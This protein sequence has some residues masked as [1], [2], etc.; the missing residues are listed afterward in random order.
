MH[1]AAVYSLTTPE[2]Q[3]GTAGAPLAAERLWK[4]VKRREP[5]KALC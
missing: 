2:G 5:A 4:S 1:Y 3:E